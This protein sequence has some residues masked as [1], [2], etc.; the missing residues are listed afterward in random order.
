M[1][2]RFADVVK[3]DENK[4][5]FEIGNQKFQL[6]NIR[7]TDKTF[8]KKNRLFLCAN[9]RLV[10]SRELEKVIVDLDSGIFEKEGYWYIGVLTGDYL[11]NNVDMNRL[12][13]DI[14]TESSPLFP[15]N[16]GLDK[17]EQSACEKIREFLQEYLSKVETEKQGKCSIV[18]T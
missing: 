9:E 15:D 12:S 2:Q 18:S 17:I 1:N 3:T 11:D 8:A 13:F 7:I 14:A 4:S 16:P 6:L 5:Y 10:Y